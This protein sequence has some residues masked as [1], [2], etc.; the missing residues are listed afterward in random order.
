MKKTVLFL[1]GMLMITSARATDN[2]YVPL[3]REG[4][5]WVEYYENTIDNTQSVKTYQFCGNIEI[6]GNVYS[7][8]YSTSRLSDVAQQDS[9]IAYVREHEKQIYSVLY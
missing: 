6:G 9:P 2:E 5:K 7:K 1:L 8:L 3:V 4:V